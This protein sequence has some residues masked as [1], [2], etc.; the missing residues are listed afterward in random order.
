MT[1]DGVSLTW[2]TAIVPFQSSVLIAVDP[3]RVA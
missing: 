3:N 1:R 2:S